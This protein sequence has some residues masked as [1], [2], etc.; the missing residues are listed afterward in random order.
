MLSVEC[1]SGYVHQG[2]PIGQEDS[3]E[4]ID[5][6]A[7][8]LDKSKDTCVIIGSDVWGHRFVNTQLE[9]DCYSE[10]LNVPCFVP[11]IFDGGAV[12][13]GT[14]TGELDRRQEMDKFVK[15]NQ[16]PKNVATVKRFIKHLRSLGYSKIAMMGFCWGGKVC[17]ALSKEES[18]DSN[19]PS[20]LNAFATAHPPPL[21]MP[22]DVAQ[23]QT[24]F[25]FVL[26]GDDTHIKAPMI[27]AIQET[28]STKNNIS[29]HVFPGMKHGFA[30]RGNKSSQN[31][32]Q[33]ADDA[34]VRVMSHFKS[35]L[36][37]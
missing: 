14:L 7:V 2:N 16:F 21:Q 1:V 15:N 31:V 27:Q 4:G 6:Y 36:V 9:A 5:Y 37:D 28:A 20:L 25:V 18:L 19:Y 24:P 30:I 35:V 11:D 33:S 3:V 13:L 29:V 12:P 8:G 23:I 34:F 26:A 32:M 10:H 22:T 17:I